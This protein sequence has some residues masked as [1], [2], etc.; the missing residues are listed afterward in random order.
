MR[1]DT[2]ILAEW[3]DAYIP[4]RHHMAVMTYGNALIG[5][6]KGYLIVIHPLDSELFKHERTASQRPTR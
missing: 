2:L 4:P 5:I 6:S 1:N 3:Y